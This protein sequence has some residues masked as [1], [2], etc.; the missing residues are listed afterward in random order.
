MLLQ[1]KDVHLRRP[2][3]LDHSS[4]FFQT[5]PNTMSDRDRS[6]SRSRS[7][8]RDDKGDNG[9]ADA[10]RDHNGGDDAEGIKLYVG[11]LDYGE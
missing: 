5:Q 1:E 7:P 11:N 6:R 10:K 9:D 8:A 4:S 2:K 3:P